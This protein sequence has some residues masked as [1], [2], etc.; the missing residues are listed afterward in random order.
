M[1]PALALRLCGAILLALLLAFPVLMP[2]P[3]QAAATA[4]LSVSLVAAKK[5]LKFGDSMVLTATATNN[6]P[7]VATGVTLHLGVSDSFADF[8]GTCPDGSISSFCDIGTLQVGASVTVHFNVGACCECCPDHIGVA[9]V[10]VG[11]DADTVDPISA[12]DSFRTETRLK[13]K[14]PF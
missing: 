1:T 8:G 14:P 9:I 5:S 11:H 12:N 13:G 6:G 4:D 10:T 2:R 3:V 7:D